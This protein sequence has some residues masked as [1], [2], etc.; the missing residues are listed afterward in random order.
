MEHNNTEMKGVLIT[1][2]GYISL[3]RYNPLPMCY[4]ACLGGLVLALE[5]KPCIQFERRLLV[6]KLSLQ[7]LKVRPVYCTYVAVIND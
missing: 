7:S 2:R 1:C 3:I 4:R 6:L 5:C